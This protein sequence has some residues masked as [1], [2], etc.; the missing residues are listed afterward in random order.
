M[1]III[2]IRFAF[3]LFKVVIVFNYNIVLVFLR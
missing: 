1:Y 2:E 3:L